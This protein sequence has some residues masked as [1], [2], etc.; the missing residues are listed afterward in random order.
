MKKY[1]VLLIILLIASNNISAQE[2]ISITHGPY[3]QNVDTNEATVVWTTNVNAISWVEIAPDDGTH[4]YLIE[5]PKIFSSENGVKSEDTV[6]AVKLRGLK[7]N[8]RY[9]YRIFSQE[10]TS[11]QGHF[12]TYGRI[13]STTAYTPNTFTTL[14]AD[15]TTLKF[16]MVNDIH[17]RSDVM[18]QMFKI[19]DP[20]KQ[21]LVFFN[22][23]MVSSF[24][25]EDDVFNGF[26]DAGVKAFAQKIPM[27][28]CRGNHETRGVFATSFQRYFSPLNP[29]LY[30][31][32]RH[33]PVCFLVLDC[34]EDKPD[35]DIEYS[36]IT[37]YD[38]YRTLEAEWLRTAV[39]DKR[40]TEAQFKIVICHMPPARDWHGEAEILDKFVPILNDA[41]VDVML[42][43]HLHRTINRAP[44]DNIKFPVLINSNNSV[45]S[46]IVENG[47]L[48]LD[49]FDLEGKRTEGKIIEK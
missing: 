11:R 25:N 20:M 33:G 28:Y 2:R 35:S 21:D 30:F 26:M 10:V 39:K 37:D 49:I 3:L 1:Y 46:G 19:V 13:A 4:F 17:G 32:V 34:G 40:F 16:C 5:R 12:I 38:Y 31:I 27:Y 22:G 24:T 14:N 45:L 36:G 6:H 43:G 8:T 23:D 9:R 15:A 41:D 48:T 42:C 18:V 7:P 44:T 29:E 47:K